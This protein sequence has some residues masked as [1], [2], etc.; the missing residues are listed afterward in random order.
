MKQCYS[1]LF[2]TFCYLIAIGQD[3]L[4]QDNNGIIVRNTND[5]IQWL[6]NYGTCDHNKLSSQDDDNNLFLTCKELSLNQLERNLLNLVELQLIEEYDDVLVSEVVPDAYFIIEDNR[7]G[8][9]DHEGNV[10]VPPVDGF[11][12]TYTQADP[13]FRM[14]S[15]IPWFIQQDIAVMGAAKKKFWG[16]W[17]TG[18][19][20]A[21]LRRENL[22]IDV[23]YGEYDDIGWSVN[24]VFMYYV[25]IYDQ[26]GEKWGALDVD[27]NIL[28]PCEYKSLLF[29]KK[30]NIYGSNDQIM[31]DIFEKTFEEMLKQRDKMERLKLRQER[32]K[33]REESMKQ[34]CATIERIGQGFIALGSSIQAVQTIRNNGNGSFTAGGG[35]LQ[36]QYSNWEKRAKMNYESLTNTGTNYKKNGND[37]AGTNGQ[38]LSPTNYV[39]QKALLREAQRQMASIRQQASSKGIHINQSKWETVTVSY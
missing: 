5:V 30:N 7:I 25:T 13:T 32:E 11:P 14:G 20:K 37:V 4:T 9:C 34:L 24:G 27:G 39:Q 17:K 26:N 8:V 36:I 35:T 33:R 15:T 28:V 1:F 38:S 2:L 31:N 21:I 6:D 16:R 22:H 29:D 19:F 3:N 18:S 10:L 23:P 12:A